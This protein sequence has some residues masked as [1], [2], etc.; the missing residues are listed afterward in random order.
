MDSKCQI[1]LPH[2]IFSVLKENKDL[3]EHHFQMSETSA[4]MGSG[5]PKTANG[6][7]AQDAAALSLLGPFEDAT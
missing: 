1:R 3:I 7:N 4:K 6:L 5:P 2:H